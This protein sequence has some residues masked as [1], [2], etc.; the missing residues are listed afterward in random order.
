MGR[1]EEAV[2]HMT[3]ALRVFD[4]EPDAE[5]K[6]SRDEMLLIQARYSIAFASIYYI[7]SEFEKAKEYTQKALDICSNESNYSYQT[8]EDFKKHIKDLE[9]TKLKCEAK[10]KNV[11]SLDLKTP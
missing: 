1:L 5:L 2:A 3:S 11:S 10:I 9:S 7:K 4:S 6:R 8:A